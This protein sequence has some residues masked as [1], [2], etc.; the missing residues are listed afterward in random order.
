MYLSKISC[1]IGTIKPKDLPSGVT[2]SEQVEQS[3][4]GTQPKRA[5]AMIEK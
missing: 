2:T 4:R 1:L 3:L 5:L